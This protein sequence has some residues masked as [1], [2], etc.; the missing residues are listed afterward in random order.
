MSA[1]ISAQDVKKLRDMTHCGMMDCKEAL[2]AAGGD[3]EKAKEILRTKGLSRAD[4]RSGRAAVEGYVGSYIHMNGRIGV[5]LELNSETD[6]VARSDDF[7]QLHKDLCL[8]VCATN[9]IS[10]SREHVPSSV[11]ESEQRIAREQVA[12]KPENIVEKI[13]T[14]KL[15][16]FFE[17]TVLLEQKFIKDDSLK[18]ADLVKQVAGKFGENIVVKRFAR[19]E[20][21][22]E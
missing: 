8:Q 14:G 2:K 21:G 12:G 16:K 1:Q 15:E 7:R 11:V 22:G 3:F 19:F 6:F 18:V 9:P 10:I 17:E 13:V 4:S 20:L 5:L